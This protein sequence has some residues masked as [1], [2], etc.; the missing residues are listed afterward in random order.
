MNMMKIIFKKD[1]FSSPIWAERSRGSAG[2]RR[3]KEF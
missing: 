2:N 3:K 1:Y